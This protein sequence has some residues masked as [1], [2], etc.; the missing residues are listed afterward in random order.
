MGNTNYSVEVSSEGKF[1]I[2]LECPSLK[3]RF[4]SQVITP[5]FELVVDENGETIVAS[6]MCIITVFWNAQGRIGLRLNSEEVVADLKSAGPFVVT[7]KGAMALPLSPFFRNMTVNM[8]LSDEEQFF[9]DTVKDLDEKLADG[10][11]YQLKKA[12][13]LIRLLLFDEYSLAITISSRYKKKLIFPTI[14][15]KSM[16]FPG[17]PIV[18]GFGLDVS[19]MPT[20]KPYLNTFDEFKDAPAVTHNNSLVS[21]KDVIK[22]IANV[23]GGVHLG[24]VRSY[25]AGQQKLLEINE[26]FVSN[27]LGLS[28]HCLVDIGRVVL[29]AMIPLVDSIQKNA[30]P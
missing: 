18:S 20:M 3:T 30:L 23:Q 24:K 17:K 28:L 8:E 12:A 2:E 29:Q 7:K 14:N 1:V 19:Y 11:P 4:V 27:E 13:A 22:L 21:V 26:D 9:L 25:E 5:P 6:F 16:V 15:Y 10:S